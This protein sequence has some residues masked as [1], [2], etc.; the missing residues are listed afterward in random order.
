MLTHF[1]VKNF[2]GFE[3][4]TRFDLRTDKKY[5]FNESAVRDEVVQHAMIYG[6]NGSGKSN[7]DVNRTLQFPNA[8]D[9]Q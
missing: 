6:E 2:R 3:D 9:N 7:L 4:W 8:R 5:V 1:A